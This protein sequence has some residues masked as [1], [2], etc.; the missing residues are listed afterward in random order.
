LSALY[1][2]NGKPYEE[3]YLTKDGETVEKDDL[4]ADRPNYML[5]VLIAHAIPKPST[6]LKP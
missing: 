6:R 1:D 4:Q 5:K 2:K 3:P